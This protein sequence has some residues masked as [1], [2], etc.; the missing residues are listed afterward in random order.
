MLKKGENM[1]KFIAFLLSAFLC[2]GACSIFAGCG[3]DEDYGNTVVIEYRT[4]TEGR[5]GIGTAHAY[6]L[7]EQFMEYAKDSYLYNFF[8]SLVHSLYD[9]KSPISFC[10]CFKQSLKSSSA[11]KNALKSHLYLS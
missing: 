3:P 10:V 8:A 11:L 4:E 5:N 9:S 6:D 7:A 2:V 1:K